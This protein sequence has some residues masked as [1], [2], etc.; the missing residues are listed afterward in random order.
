MA[1]VKRSDP[2]PRTL[3]EVRKSQETPNPPGV[4]V[5]RQDKRVTGLHVHPEGIAMLD[6]PDFPWRP[7][8]PVAKVKRGIIR[9]RLHIRFADGTKTVIRP[10]KPGFKGL[11]QAGQLDT[12]GDFSTASGD[13]R[14]NSSGLETLFAPIIV[15][16]AVILFPVSLWFLAREVFGTS[17][18]AKQADVVLAQIRGVIAPS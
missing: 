9:S 2:L 6:N 3:D 17:A 1:R 10:Y 11:I 18:R 13:G 5:V 7:E 14:N 16:A 12:I 4:F 15:I 8:P